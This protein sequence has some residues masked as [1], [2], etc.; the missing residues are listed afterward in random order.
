[1]RV[2]L[3]T[4]PVDWSRGIALSGNFRR[5]LSPAIEFGRIRWD[6]AGAHRDLR[7]QAVGWGGTEDEPDDALDALEA[8]T[9]VGQAD[10][11][12]G[13]PGGYVAPSMW[14]APG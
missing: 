11:F 5:T 7:V 6:D 2:T 14:D 8:A 10:A 9:R 13:A 4:P 12:T 1:M 3:A